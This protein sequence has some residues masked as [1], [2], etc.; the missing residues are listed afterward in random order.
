M[1]RLYPIVSVICLALASTAWAAKNDNQNFLNGKPFQY[2]NQ[3]IEINTDAIASLGGQAD[4]VAS[5]LATLE[6]EVT[7]NTAAITD[8]LS[9]INTL[10]EQVGSLQ[11]DVTTL[12]GELY[13]LKFQHERDIA[14]L[15]AQLDDLRSQVGSLTAQLT[16]LA[17]DL[18]ISVARLE[19][20]IEANSSDIQTLTTTVSL[21]SG[22]VSLAE[23]EIMGLLSRISLVEQGLD[24]QQTILDDL[25][26]ALVALDARV[27]LLEPLDI[28][29]AV[30]FIQDTLADDLQGPELAEFFQSVDISFDW[31][32]YME[33][34]AAQSGAWCSS[35]AGWYKDN[36]LAKSTSGGILASGRWDKWS[37]SGNG[38]WVTSY[39][40]YKNYY[41]P[42]CS[43]GGTQ[44]GWCAEY[45]IGGNYI[46]YLP[47]W[48]DGPV[49][50]EV[51]N[52]GSTG[53]GTLTV[54][55]AATRAEACGF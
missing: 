31:F 55:L 34:N 41:G 47:N 37:R 51:Y 38:T 3:Q 54:R 10:E 1:N 48:P 15:R 52:Y 27:S 4:D 30:F 16:D 26:I 23:V 33:G 29:G 22:R 53:T 32:I 28:G 46:A 24:E 12:T 13:E 42:S 19:D 50:H 25:G 35:N 21:L 40:E 20:A 14:S 49:G 5:Q 45:G 11:R 7:S 17:D 44:W 8:A 39:E 43:G 36:Y 18:A 2:L 9:R 6:A